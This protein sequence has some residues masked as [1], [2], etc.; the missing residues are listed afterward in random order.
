MAPIPDF[1]DSRN[2]S[3]SCR[4]LSELRSHLG[5]DPFVKF[6]GCIRV[7]PL[8][9]ASI[10]HGGAGCNAC[11]RAPPRLYACVSCAAVACDEHAPP[12][13]AE[14]SHHV[15]VDVARAEL[16]CCA[17]GDQVYDRDFDAAVAAAAVGAGP[18]PPAEGMRKRRRVDYK[19]WAPDLKERALI[20]EKSSPLPPSQLGGDSV[21]R[22]EGGAVLPWGLRGLNNLG[23]SCFMNSVLQALLHT[24]PLRNYFLSDKHNRFYCERENRTIVTRKVDITKGNNK[25]L[26]LCL[27]CDLDAIFSAA[28]SGDRV[29]YSPAKFF[30]RSAF[31]FKS[32]CGCAYIHFIG[33]LPIFR[34][35]ILRQT[36][37]TQVFAFSLYICHSD[38]K[39]SN[40]LY[41]M[42]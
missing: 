18:L 12:H 41:V 37:C 23:S 39:R 7:P 20:A 36:P 34:N 3:Y 11:G 9:R 5:P 24:P 29:P 30:H 33:L 25:S 28:F 22:I 14:T 42:F 26:Q 19:P 6:H 32:V 8:G 38:S 13:A 16:F 35:Q 17:C 15:A 21:S 10:S 40:S 31:G 2:P 1:R 27:A 4:H